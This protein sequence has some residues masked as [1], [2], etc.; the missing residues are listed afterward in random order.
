[1]NISLAICITHSSTYCLYVYSMKFD[2][3]FAKL[4]PNCRE[5]S[6]RAVQ[7][8]TKHFTLSSSIS[9]S[10]PINRVSN[11]LVANCILYYVPMLSS[12]QDKYNEIIKTRKLWSFPFFCIDLAGFEMSQKYFLPHFI[13]LHNLSYLTLPT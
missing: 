13:S 8:I 2:K 11:F 9:A 6:T 12:I 4:S 1:M 7:S 5:M 3:T 10:L